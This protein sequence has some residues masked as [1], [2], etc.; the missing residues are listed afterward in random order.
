MHL[1]KCYKET[2]KSVQKNEI[3]KRIMNKVRVPE[4]GG[5]IGVFT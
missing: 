3:P 4:T 1:L 2:H 5:K